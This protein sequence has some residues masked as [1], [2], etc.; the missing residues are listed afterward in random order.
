MDITE[1]PFEFCALRFLVQWEQGEKALHEQ[2]AGNPSLTQIRS[3]LRYFQV[4]RTFKG[5]KSDE[6]AQAVADAFREVAGRSQLSPEEKVS[7]LASRFQERFKQ[8]NLSASSKLLWLKFKEPYVI[9]DS[10]AVRALKDMGCKL[11]DK[12]TYGEYCRHWREHYGQREAA[13]KKAA[14]RLPEVKAFLPPWHRTEAELT[15]LAAQP[16][17]LERVFDIYLWE[18]GGEG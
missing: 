5:L 12:I 18:R 3:A 7:A 10:R 6:A 13:I 8:F 14:S 11:K 15:Q 1:L 2:I 16:W 4:A 9:Y 17:F